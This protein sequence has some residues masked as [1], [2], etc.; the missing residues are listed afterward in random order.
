[1]SAGR[2]SGV[3]VCQCRRLLREDPGRPRA[4]SNE[5][6]NGKK[7][8]KKEESTN[9]SGHKLEETTDI[10][11]FFAGKSVFLTGITGF[12]GK[13]S[14]RHAGAMSTVLLI[15]LRTFV[16]AFWAFNSIVSA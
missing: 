4:S 10:A 12:L 5:T 3:L 2:S 16:R 14:S 7:Q 1:M 9:M 13:V 6:G 11:E 8:E 15:S